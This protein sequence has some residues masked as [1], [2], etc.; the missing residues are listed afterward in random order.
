MRMMIFM[1]L[2]WAFGCCMGFDDDDDD[3]V[4]VR[5]CECCSGRNEGDC[6]VMM[7]AVVMTTTMLMMLMTTTMMMVIC[8][9]RYGL[10]GAC[11][12]A[13]PTGSSHSQTQCQVRGK[14]AWK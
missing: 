7:V 11:D 8:L 9:C 3:D 4:L 1:C 13:E 2:V 14:H 10:V 12:R 5:T 6:D